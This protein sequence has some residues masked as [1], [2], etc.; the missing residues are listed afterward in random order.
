M[1]MPARH[2]L[3]ITA[4]IA[5]LALLLPGCKRS[6]FDP[7]Q[8][9]GAPA[10]VNTGQGQQLWLATVQE[11]QYQIRMGRR[12]SGVMLETRYHLLVQAHDP[13][14]MQRTWLKELKM[15]RSK[16]GGIG[17][18][19][20]IMGQQ[21]DVVWVWLHDQPL[22]L[23]ARDASVLA[24][25][26]KLE[27]ANPALA[28]LFPA[29]ID[30]YTWMGDH[31]VVGLADGRHVRITLPGFRAE[32]Y[33]IDD[34]NAFRYANNLTA[35][36]NGGFR[37]EEFGVRHGLFGERWIG[38]LSDKEARDGENDG[39][40]GNYADSA[41]IDTERETAR[42]TFRVATVGRTKAFSEGSHPRIVKL[43]PIADA[44][45]WLQGTLLK[46]SAVPGASPFTLRGRMWR[47]TVRPPLQ[48]RNPDGVLVLHKTRIDEQGRL[49]IA[50]VNEQF[51]AM[52]T[53][54]LP[55]TEL[56]N[57]WEA[58]GHLLLMGGWDEGQ[59]GMSRHQEALLSLD[60]TTGKLQGR[61]VGDEKA[62]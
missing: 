34:E 26:A 5:L 55:F 61:H 54:V 33:Q 41:E 38:L 44:G 1:H 47:P 50:R 6:S 9:M 27:Q 58:D 51:Q 45:T 3:R 4:C 31:L 7:P 39:F 18:Q 2:C 37:T 19:V 40:G 56:T 24:D 46:A 23:S 53:T 49:A 20:R 16:E 52:W 42:R 30:Y 43:N 57:R 17:A 21:G 8:R 15:L 29:K 12:S 32:P 36:W 14:S 62:L 22:A 35:R 28:G 25:R 48:L 60:L 59:P 10:L 11:E 13:A